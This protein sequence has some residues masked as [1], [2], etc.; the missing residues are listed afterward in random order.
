M[1]KAICTLIISICL[2]SILP[3]A[4]M[5]ELKTKSLSAVSSTQAILEESNKLE[6]HIKNSIESLID[7]YNKV[8]VPRVEV[9]ADFSSFDEEARVVNVHLKFGANNGMAMMKKLME[10]YSN[11]IA[12]RVAKYYSDKHITKINLFWEAPCFIDIGNAA[13]FQYEI[14]E[15]W[16]IL[17]K[18]L[19]PLYGVN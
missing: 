2:L 19:G 3:V 10:G 7:N 17:N 12:G 15:G 4:G 11:D 9:N 6:Y 5:S 13:K 14:Y 16:L 1:K 8:S 18:K